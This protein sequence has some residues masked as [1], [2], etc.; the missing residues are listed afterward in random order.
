MKM[1]LGYQWDLLE[2]E[3]P[4]I[5]KQLLDSMN[6]CLANLQSE[7]RGTKTGALKFQVKR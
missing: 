5:F 1:E 3:I 2:D 6:H 4:T 7:I